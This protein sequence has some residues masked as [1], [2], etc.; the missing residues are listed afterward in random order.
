MQI[1]V[2]LLSLLLFQAECKSWGPQRHDVLMK[3]FLNSR[4]LPIA[5]V[6]GTSGYSPSRPTATNSNL[7]DDVARG[8]HASVKVG[9]EQIEQEELGTQ[10]DS[11]DTKVVA[12]DTVPTSPPSTSPVIRSS[13]GIKAIA[14]DLTNSK[15]VESGKG[16]KKKNTSSAARIAKKLRVSED[17]KIEKLCQVC[18]KPSWG[19]SRRLEH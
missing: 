12:A 19:M 6:S 18:R 1:V 16:R 9:Q 2:S 13:H 17:S 5:T 8:G 14:V 15:T 11:L 10:T 4:N 7:S 3:D